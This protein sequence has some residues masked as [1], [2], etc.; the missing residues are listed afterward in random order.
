MRRINNE[1]KELK[2]KLER[3]SSTSKIWLIHPYPMLNILPISSTMAMQNPPLLG[4]LYSVY[5]QQVVPN[6]PT[7]V[8]KNIDIFQFLEDLNNTR[9]HVPSPLNLAPSTAPFPKFKD[10]LLKF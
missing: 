9:W 10:Y 8:I 6:Y 5:A 2:H 3:S 7:K 1:I 4:G